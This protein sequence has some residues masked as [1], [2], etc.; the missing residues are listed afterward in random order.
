MTGEQS[1]ILALA[2]LILLLAVSH[3]RFRTRTGSVLRAGAFLATAASAFFYWQQASAP[4]AIPVYASCP[5]PKQRS[6]DPQRCYD[7]SDVAQF[8]R[9][10]KECKIVPGAA[11]REIENAPGVDSRGVGCDYFDQFQNHSRAAA[12]ATAS[13]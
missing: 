3:A 5:F 2:S 13:R 6:N 4:P 10:L 11:S 1:V 8:S 9:H 7:P 12:P